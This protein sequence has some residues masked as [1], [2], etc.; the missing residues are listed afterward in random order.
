MKGAR[1]VGD[2][3]APPPGSL[4]IDRVI[5]HAGEREQPQTRASLE[6]RV[7]KGVAA[8]PHERDRVSAQ[9]HERLETRRI[10]AR[11]DLH[12]RKRPQPLDP[13]P[14]QAHARYGDA[15]AHCV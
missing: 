15:D 1:G 2:R 5:A 4:D 3:H 12:V 9:C 13:G 7:A 11:P 10:L 8:D 14:R 6:K